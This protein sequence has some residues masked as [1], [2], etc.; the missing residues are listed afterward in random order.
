MLYLSFMRHA[1]ADCTNYDGNDFN[2]PI[3]EKGR[4]KTE[5]ISE[6]LSEKKIIFDLIFCSPSLRTKQTLECL[7]KN[8]KL[9]KTKILEDYDLYDGNEDSFLL[10]LYNL[11]KYKNLLIISHEPQIESFTNYFL[12]KADNKEKSL[13]FVFVTSSIITIEFKSDLWKNIS[14]FNAK[15]KTFID[16]NTLI[17]K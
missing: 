11:K 17:T 4:K 15:L 13:D 5:I 7:I 3:S 1:K 16:P 6:H 14:S 10:K 12:S 2:R 9:K 8:N